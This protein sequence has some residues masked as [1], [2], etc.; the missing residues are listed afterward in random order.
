MDILMNALILA[1][2]F[3]V[4]VI[5]P[6][7]DLVVAIRNSIAHGRLIGFFTALGFGLAIIVH[8]TYT[9]FG[10]AALIASSVLVFTIIKIIGACYL[11]YVGIKALRSNGMATVEL[12][13]PKSKEEMTALKACSQGFITNLLNPKA[14]LFFLALFSQFIKEGDPIWVYGVYGSICFALVVVW[15]SIVSIFLTIPMVRNKFLAVSKWVDRVC[16]TLF[17][18]LGI[19]LATTKNPS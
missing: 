12:D 1:G 10:I 4:A 7:P 14:A 2:V 17:I 8:V 13:T 15:F 3:G 5:S 6:G 11:F 18:A 19:K 16:G 9:S